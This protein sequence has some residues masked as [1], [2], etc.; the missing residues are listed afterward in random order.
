MKKTE[1]FAARTRMSSIWACSLRLALGVK[2]LADVSR[3]RCA[4]SRIRTS[5]SARRRSVSRKYLNWVE[6]RRAHDAAE[7][8]RECLGPG[9]VRAL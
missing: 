1:T 5:M 3:I 8:L 9:H 2:R 7:V 6:A 4:S